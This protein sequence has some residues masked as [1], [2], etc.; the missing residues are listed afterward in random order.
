MTQKRQMPRVWLGS[1]RQWHWISSAV[2]LVGMVLFAFTGITLNHAGQIESRPSVRTIEQAL[3]EAVLAELV[4][5]SQSPDAPEEARLPGSL[6]NWLASQDI[7]VG[8][9]VAE[10]SED[11]IYLSL[12]RPGGDAWLAIDLQLGE[13]LYEDTDRGLVSYLN[14]LHKARNTGEAWKWFIDIFS[15]A[16]LVFCGTGLWL[17]IRH[18]SARPSTWPVV[19]LGLVLPLL[20]II[21]FVH[22]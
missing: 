14:D 21:L 11:E 7:S 17:L 10:W 22:Q 18:S 16:C 2:C 9:R 3:P 8:G 19:G 20:L 12:P 15:V 4:T 1:V 6:R 13:L 5:L